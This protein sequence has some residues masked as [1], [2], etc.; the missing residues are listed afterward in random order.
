MN[1]A[2]GGLRL[3]LNIFGKWTEVGFAFAALT[4]VGEVLRSKQ[5]KSAL[6]PSTH[7]SCKLYACA[8][9]LKKC[10]EEESG[11]LHV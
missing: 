6:G 11:C 8:A 4:R 10:R 3:L 2:S 7:D 1:L 5:P 9:H